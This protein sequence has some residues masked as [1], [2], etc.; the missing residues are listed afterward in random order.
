MNQPATQIPKPTISYATLV[1]RIV[2]HHRTHSHIHQEAMAQVLGIS[3]SAY[4]RLEQGQS[5]M[6]VTQLRM[7][8][9]KLGTTPD[10]LLQHTAQYANQL[11][12]QKVAI[13]DE[14]QGSAAGALIALGIL[15]ALFAA[16]NSK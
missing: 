5:A 11:R 3:Q 12:A 9:E 2:E 15:A 8:A 13:T 6:S 1:G 4:S 7:I 10:F 16:A 14:K